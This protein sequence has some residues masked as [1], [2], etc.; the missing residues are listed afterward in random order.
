MA[1]G[2]MAL[3]LWVGFH[4]S[5]RAGRVGGGGDQDGDC[6]QALGGGGGVYVGGGEQIF[7]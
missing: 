4:G 7:W 2:S 5:A 6:I 3:H 1:T